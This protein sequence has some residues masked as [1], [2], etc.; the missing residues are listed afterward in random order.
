MVRVAEGGAAV[1]KD[2]IGILGKRLAERGEP[3]AQLPRCG[4]CCAGVSEEC[5]RGVNRAQ[6]SLQMRWHAAPPLAL[7]R[8]PLA[9]GRVP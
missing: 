9:Q 7:L 6:G 3:A 4:P 5:G 8:Q 2:E 1:V